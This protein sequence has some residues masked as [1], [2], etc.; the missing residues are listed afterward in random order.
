VSSQEKQY[1]SDAVG[2]V[3]QANLTDIITRLN[4]LRGPTDAKYPDTVCINSLQAEINTLKTQIPT[5]TKGQE[6]SA[7][8]FYTRKDPTLLVGGVAAG[9]PEDYLKKLKI[10]L[11]SQVTFKIDAKCEPF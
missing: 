1:D 2:K 4:T 5:K 7:E 3:S 8:P 6:A 9:W 11:S 10:R